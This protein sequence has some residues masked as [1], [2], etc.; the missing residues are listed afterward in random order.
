MKSKPKTGRS[1]PKSIDDYLARVSDDQ[2]ITLE[3]LRRTIKAAVPSLEECMAYQIPSFRLGGKYLIS[4]AAWKEHCA[5]YPGSHPIKTHREAL[6]AYDTNKGTV[7]FPANKPLPTV[8]VRKLVR[9]R[10]AQ[11]V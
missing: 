8:L 11:V 4:F 6:K 3:K 10:I 9:S 1:A 7:R 2:R 5:F